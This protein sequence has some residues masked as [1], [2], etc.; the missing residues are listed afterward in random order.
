[1]STTTQPKSLGVAPWRP[2]FLSHISQM[3]S[4][5]FVL[6]TLVPA[7]KGSPTPYLPRAR[8]C[9]YR[10]LWA[11]LPENHHNEAP[12]N[13]RVYESDMLTFTS[14]VRMSKIPEIFASSAGHGDVSQSQGS[15]GGGPVEA[16]FWVKE[17]KTQ[18][19]ISG[20]A[21]VV[22]S[23]VEGDG[24][25]SSGVRTLKSEVGARMRLV[26]EEKK[27]EWS[28]GKE[29]TAHFGN[30]SPGMRGSF[31]NPP[32]GTPVSKPLEDK[33]LQLGQKIK[34]LDHETAR[35][36]FRVVIIKPDAVEQVDLTDP[37][38]S[39]RWKYTWVGPSG[40]D[41]LTGGWTS[42]ELWP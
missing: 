11:E 34:E 13:E 17:T 16:V 4:P 27:D 24:D 39:R 26:K 38:A 25:E 15:G 29:L 35:K 19:R 20:T 5:E 23:D 22:A 6:A 1:M 31:A 10:G 7:P 14:D 21:F 33:S 9:I 42:E 8:T 40:D 36:N 41:E 28:W 3:S 32:P 30:V 12:Q 18:W 37:D 2:Q